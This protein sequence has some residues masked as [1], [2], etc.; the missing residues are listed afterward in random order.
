MIRCIHLTHRFEKQLSAMRRSSKMA[1]AA[2]RKADTIINRLTANGQGPLHEA[3]KL[4]NHGERRI[5]HAVKFDIGKGYRM[6]GVKKDDELFLLFI[7]PHDSCAA[8][9]E[10]NRGVENPGDLTRIRTLPVTQGDSEPAVALD[11]CRE[12]DYDDL[13]LARVTEQDLCV[14]FR[15]LRGQ[16]G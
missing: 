6:L 4:S 1:V 3:G 2:G 11:G 12:P 7:G 8:W 9:I 15:G 13:L 14:I 5:R 16:N 10:N